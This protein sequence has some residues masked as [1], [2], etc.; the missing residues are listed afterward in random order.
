M[1]TLSEKWEPQTTSAKLRLFQAHND[2]GIDVLLEEISDRVRSYQGQ[3]EADDI[4]RDSLIDEIGSRLMSY[5]WKIR[6]GAT[7]RMAVSTVQSD[8]RQKLYVGLEIRS[9]GTSPAV[10]KNS[11]QLLSLIR[12]NAD[13][14]AKHFPPETLRRWTAEAAELVKELDRHT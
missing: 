11:A 1:T 10:Q 13:F 14:F 4:T 2:V 7:T 9:A 5:L 6:Y 12:G 8:D 3:P